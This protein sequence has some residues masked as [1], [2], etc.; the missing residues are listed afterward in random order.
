VTLGSWPAI[1]TTRDSPGG[2][3][4][5]ISIQSIRF[6]RPPPPRS[7]ETRI[8]PANRRRIEQRETRTPSLPSANRLPVHVHVALPANCADALVF[9]R[10]E[11][12]NSRHSLIGQATLCRLQSCCRLHVRDQ[13]RC[14]VR[15]RRTRRRASLGVLRSASLFSDQ[16]ASSSP[17]LGSNVTAKSAAKP[18][19]V[20]CRAAHEACL[21]EQR[22]DR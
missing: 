11:P 1:R 22:I 7:S 14:P 2:T 8:D 13:N 10:C 21:G 19:A 4:R 12:P 16:G 9:P 15:C 6:S 20:P 3:D 18:I 5:P 17:V